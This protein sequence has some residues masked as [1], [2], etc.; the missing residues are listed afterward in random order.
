MQSAL[1]L[2]NTMRVH[3]AVLVAT[4]AF[5]LWAGWD[6]IGPFGG[7]AAVIQ[8]DGH[9]R[10]TVLAA[11]S[12]AQI[13]RSEDDGDSWRALPF[14]AQF[15]ATLHA[16]VLDPQNPGVYL[17][18]LSSDNPEYS[19]LF[20]SS[21][22]GLTWKR[23][24]EN[25]LQAVWSIAIWPRDSRVWAAGTPDG[26]LLTHD[27]GGSWT[28]VAP[29]ENRGPKPV[30]SLAFDP[31][32]SKTLYVGTPHL[33]WKTVDGGTSWNSIHTGMLDDSD[34]FSIDVDASHPLKVFASACSGIYRSSN[35]GATW[36]KLVRA[37]G[38]SYRTYQITQDP[39]QPNI[40]FA[41]TTSGLEKSVD[42][43]A[44]W[45]RLSTQSTRSI[46]F[47]PG[48]PGRIFVATDDEGLFRSDDLGESLHAINQGFCNRRLGSLA[49]SGKALYINSLQ[50]SASGPILRLADSEKTWAVV[51]AVTKLIRKQVV[52]IVSADSQR[53]YIVTSSSLVVS[54][55][56]GTSWHEIS[57][58][59]TSPLTDLLVP[60]ADGHRLL[61]GTEN[62]VFQTENAGQTWN[63]GAPALL[64]PAGPRTAGDVATPLLVSSSDGVGYETPK[65]PGSDYE[66]YGIVATDHNGFLAATSR[67]LMRSDEVEKTWRPLPGLLDGSTVTA[68]CKHPTRAGVIFASK[69]G[70]LFVSKDEGQSWT[71]L[72]SEGD[73]TEVI[74]ELL[75]VPA[76]PDRVFALTRGHGI[77][78]ISLAGL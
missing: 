21:D 2:T 30:V 67:G 14:P 34:V 22:S 18:G 10:G 28:H 57:A 78:S 55:D 68:I 32:D 64:S 3:L 37:Q 6:A 62:G 31:S 11:T 71:S 73:G 59:S 26:V 36:T 51:P 5:P 33:P 25:D 77:F 44:T 7:S 75:V 56:A 47:D 50:N 19:G 43:G 66:I 13:F 8:V 61:V 23:I 70:V 72:G 24:A 29:R 16:F 74:T 35:A 27:A 58:P 69:F 52:R 63:P 76:I 54:T 40:V 1:L 38:A 45:R 49:A 41:G 48:R 60:T 46:A 9:H 53:L 42:G 17:V 20:R 15:R 4:L 65:H 39:A 12:N